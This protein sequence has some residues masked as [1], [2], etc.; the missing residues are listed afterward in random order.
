[1]WD[2]DAMLDAMPSSVL[3]EWMA[4][5]TVEPLDVG[6]RAEAGSAIV[7]SILAN[8]Y[9]DSQKQ[10]LAYTAEDFLPAWGRR[11]AEPEP[12]AV[13]QKLKNWALRV[14]KKQ[15]KAGAE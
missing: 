13:W 10:P 6:R 15:D 2:V 7:A 11:Q 9:R 5:D 14:G 3:S 4:F 8:V 1:V 12:E